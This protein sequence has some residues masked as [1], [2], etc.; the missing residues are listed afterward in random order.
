[1]TDKFFNFKSTNQSNRE[2]FTLKNTDILDEI[3]N[4]VK[5]LHS[6]LQDLY[7]WSHKSIDKNEK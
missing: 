3:N 7:I 4:G 1:M 2:Y 5:N 6:S